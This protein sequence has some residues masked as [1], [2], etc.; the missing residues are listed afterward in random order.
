MTFKELP[1]RVATLWG[2]RT[3]STKKFHLDV[4]D[5]VHTDGKNGRGIEVVDLEDGENVRLRAATMA[6]KRELL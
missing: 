1:S 6:R 3:L 2:T 5:E 4:L